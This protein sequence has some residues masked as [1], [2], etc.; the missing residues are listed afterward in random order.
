[1]ISQVVQFV[2]VLERVH[3][4]ISILV[5]PDLVA[6]PRTTLYLSEVCCPSPSVSGLWHCHGKKALQPTWHLPRMSEG[7]FLYPSHL[8]S[9]TRKYLN[10]D[11]SASI[12]LDLRCALLIRD[13]MSSFRKFFLGYIFE[14]FVFLYK[15]RMPIIHVLKVVCL[16]IFHLYFNPVVFYSASSMVIPAISPCHFQP[17]ISLICHLWF[18][19]SVITSFCFSF[20][21][22]SS[23]I[24]SFILINCLMSFLWGPVLLNS[25]SSWIFYSDIPLTVKENQH[26]C[27]WVS[28][29]FPESC[30]FVCSVSLL[31][32][33]LLVF[34]VVDLHNFCTPFYFAHG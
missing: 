33:T 11:H 21:P 19:R 5:N 2:F 8:I 10:F 32:D 25:Y 15:P 18:M 23:T 26:F 16:C 9:W 1:M 3:T 34:V 4:L 28:F 30:L 17:Y 7:S 14:F 31:R 24:S 6:P 27:L 22:L 12:F 29:L 20:F 13:Y